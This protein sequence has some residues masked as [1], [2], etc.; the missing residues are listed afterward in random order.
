LKLFD[1]FLSK[2]GVFVLL[3]G[4]TIFSALKFNP[5]LSFPSFI[6][7]GLGDFNDFGE[8]GSGAGSGGGGGED[9]GHTF[10]RELRR[11]R[12]GTRLEVG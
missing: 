1:F 10:F 11:S 4:I 6:A 9:V 2:V 3:F 5:P 7:G 12:L 8:I